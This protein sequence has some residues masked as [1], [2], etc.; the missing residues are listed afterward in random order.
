MDK[1]IRSSRLTLC[2]IVVAV[3]A[4]AFALS[5]Q[6]RVDATTATGA[7]ITRPRI[8]IA[9][10]VSAAT[11]AKLPLAFEPN[12][13]QADPRAQ[14]IAHTPG[15]SVFLTSTGAAV[16]AVR[17]NRSMRSHNGAALANIRSTM[18]GFAVTMNFP[19]ANP[20]AAASATDRLPGVSNYFIGNKPANWK[21]GIPNFAKVRYDSIYPGI[22]L[23]YY[24]NRGQLEYDLIVK[25]GAD[26]GAVRLAFNGAD[27]LEFNS[28][29]DA[30]VKSG[31][32]EM[33]LRR[34][35]G[36]QPDGSGQTPVAVSYYKTG[37]DTLG[38]R[39]TKYDRTR[40]LIIDPTL[41]Y[42]TYLGD[43]FAEAQAVA[44]NPSVGAVVAGWIAQGSSYPTTTGPF[45]PA[46]GS[47]NAVVTEFNAS[48]T[49]LAY[50]AVF[51]G[52]ED[53]TTVA[54]TST[55]EA[56][57]VALDSSGN[58]YLTGFTNAVDFPTINTSITGGTT[59][60]Q[61]VNAA[62]H[63]DAFATEINTS[64]GLV[65]ST[66][67][68][69][70][71]SDFGNAIAVDSA[72]NAYVAGNTFSTDFPI[73][74]GNAFQIT[75]PSSGAVVEGFVTKL[76]VVSGNVT[77]PYSTYFGEAASGNPLAN[78]T[79]LNGIAA[80]GSGNAYV[81]GSAGS[82][83]A[84]T[85]GS[86][87]GTWDAIAG[88][89]DTTL[90]GTASRIWATYL[91][92][93]AADWANAIAITPG[94]VSK[95]P[96]YIAG[97]TTS[98]DFPTTSDTGA[99]QVP[100]QSTLGGVVD[101]FVAQ[102]KATDGTPF[103]STLLGGESY[104][105]VRAIAVD[106]FGTAQL[107]GVTESTSYPTQSATSGGLSASLKGPSG[108]L[109]TS[110]NGGVT[111]TA[112][113]GWSST[114]GSIR[115]SS[116]LTFDTSTVPATIY[117]GSTTGLWV[118]TN[119]GSTFTQP[120]ATGLSGAIES[121][122][123]SPAGL[124]AGTTAGLFLS[125]DS[126][127]TFSNLSGI[128]GT[129]AVYNVG[130]IAQFASTYTAATSNGFYVSDDSGTTFTKATGIPNKT[131][132]FAS[133]IDA[134]T[135]TMVGPPTCTIYVGTDK[136]VYQGTVTSGSE[137]LA[138]IQTNLNYATVTGL[139][140][141]ASTLPTTLY[142]STLGKAGVVVSTSGFSSQTGA[143]EYTTPQN[144]FAVALDTATSNPA[145]VYAGAS[146]QAL[147]SVFA[148]TNGGTSYSQQ[149]SNIAG[150]ITALQ[151]L[152]GSPPKL[153][154]G[155]FLTQD[156]FITQLNGYGSQVL[157]SGYLGGT[158]ADVGNGIATDS[159]G[160]SYAAGATFSTDFLTS[161]S[162]TPYQ[163]TL[164]AGG[165]GFVNAFVTDV[166]LGALVPTPASLI[167]GSVLFG[168]TGLT[169]AAL[170][171][172]LTN[173]TPN[174][175][176]LTAAPVITG[177]FAIG[178]NTCTNGATLAPGASCT[179]HVTFT[180]TALGRRL[181]LLT[182]TDNASNSPQIH[183]FGTGIAPAIKISPTTLGFAKQTQ[184]TTS[185]AKL[186]TLSNSSGVGE[187]ITGFSVVNSDF[188]VSSTSGGATCGAT[189]ITLNTASSCTI[190]V[191]FTPS[192]GTTEQG[193]LSITD[194]ASGSPQKVSLTGIGA[195]VT[196]TATPSS[197]VFPARAVGTT[198]PGS[199]VTLKN[200]SPVT[201]NFTGAF[202]VTGA[203]APDFTKTGTTCGAS[204]AAAGSCTVTLT[205]KPSI[206][207][208]ETAT[209][210]IP[211]S[212]TSGPQ[213][214]PLSGS[215]VA[216]LLVSPASTTFA[217]RTHGTTSADKFITVKNTT[218]MASVTISSIA[219]SNSTVFTIDGAHTTCG[220]SPTYSTSLA[221]GASCKIAVK[222]TPT[223]A[224]TYH[225]VIVITDN[226][227]HS[228]QQPEVSGTG[229]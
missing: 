69:G 164:G 78:G 84:V 182:Y 207:G 89:I 201:I 129:L 44:I 158:S 208:S 85:S 11:Y 225:A 3:V 7:G 139:A 60:N 136:G 125:T 100:F 58:I 157:F 175:V 149:H 14:Y 194:N 13:G 38:V 30:I 137:A 147:T 216:T 180:P 97:G 51:G 18:S 123:F 134:N 19:G 21:T 177:D 130:T 80:D 81:A 107:T 212:S 124:F 203:N 33:V 15:A 144:A 22:D 65:Y 145:T 169:S 161:V 163:T 141:D 46:A 127:A 88:R 64:T 61:G 205:F 55:D 96:A 183:L 43:D 185:P 211:N 229:L 48:G 49:A 118:S 176:T 227:Q 131:Q 135:C 148:S 133:V 47:A 2:G 140:A 188:A 5:G 76:T 121:L 68:G 109:F 25:P 108:A 27:A 223:A 24:G 214:V 101:G 50:S 132:V 187:T 117:A 220:T 106:P 29:G 86:F 35:I 192:T 31:V 166:N 59:L 75:N 114:Q 159:A 151:V 1:S 186:I 66:Y 115:S 45:G 36:Y 172:K 42:S 16:R 162:P 154:I 181:G 174:T 95:C 23:V 79:M 17:S 204:L 71:A 102:L 10:Q 178:T 153:F 179:T 209:L 56:L 221:S 54:G 41:I 197:L 39:L 218:L 122:D 219:S 116:G 90:S 226:A 87:A 92:G 99:G 228:P 165:P 91:G 120:S 190:S 73:T 128:P 105:E 34:P 83:F 213:S 143:T 104:D 202:T 198:S 103:Y 199:V 200:T 146:S 82:G 217:S 138:V 184:G 32:N 37:R 111:L 191:T 57:G 152:A 173:A 196:I 72:G 167:F 142:A 94:C 74:S 67:L 222:F 119:G 210:N 171:V 28:A 40:P 189:P 77:N 160:N 168:N 113:S 93:S 195:A 20:H 206:I 126:G 215:G 224:T 52:S 62:V 98:A 110:T 8:A 193:S 63:S 70:S 9:P 156:A 155:E 150:S 112:V 170:T 53:E 26:A 4:A 6:G 12:R